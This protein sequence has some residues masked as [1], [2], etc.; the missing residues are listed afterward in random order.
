VPASLGLPARDLARIA[1]CMLRGGRWQDRQVIPKCSVDETAAPTH[2]V[3]GPEMRFRINAESFSHGGELPARWTGPD[4][5]GGQDAR[6]MPSSGGQRGAF[7]TSL[8]LVVAR[9]T[10]GSGTWEYEEF[11]RRACAAVV[12]AKE[13]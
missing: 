7:L 4:G 1:Y 11:L 8:D 13:H 3:K 5:R 2:A 10:G 6:F 9:Q 12:P